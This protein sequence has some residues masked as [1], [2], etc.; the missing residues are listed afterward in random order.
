MNKRKTVKAFTSFL[1]MGALAFSMSACG[2]NGSTD[3]S[4]HEEPTFADDKSLTIG[5]WVGPS[6]YDDA[7]MKYLQESGVDTLYLLADAYDVEGT[8][9]QLA[10]LE[11]A[12]VSAY[13][14]GGNSP[15]RIDAMEKYQDVPNLKGMTFDEPNRADIDALSKY[16]AKYSSLA[17]GKNFFVNFFP[18]HWTGLESS[19]EFN[20]NYENY[21]QYGY[22]K[23]ISK[24]DTGEKWISVDRYPLKEDKDEKATDDYSPVTDDASLVVWD[25]GWLHDLEA[26]AILGNKYDLKTNFFIQTMPYLPSHNVM[27]TYEDIRM[28][29]YT[30]LAFGYDGVAEFCYG[31]PPIGKEFQKEQVAMIDREGNPTAIYKAAKKANSEVKKFD[32]AYLAFDWQG[33]FT[34]DA[35]KT[36]TEKER[37]TANTSFQNLVGRLDI[38][39]IDSVQ[40]VYSS[41]DTLFGYFKDTKKRESFVVVNYN[42]TRSA[43]SDIVRI[44]FDSKT[45]RYCVVYKGGEKKI[46]ELSNGMLELELEVGEGTFVIPY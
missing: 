18:S 22:D 27:P 34:N 28:Q 36:I 40:S 31:T 43:Q 45:Y 9:S 42:E 12:G 13:L 39:D 17:N 19:T 32:H 6:T 37:R 23:L 11:K 21:L 1:L 25:S 5:G 24:S 8:K 15:D 14:A 30:A 38:A 35:G 41:R 4:I 26:A 10:A 44:A 7:Q 16:V 3:N 2:G 20:G 29:L 46:T 33:V